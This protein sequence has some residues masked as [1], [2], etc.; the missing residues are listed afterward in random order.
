MCD[1]IK[2]NMFMMV[3]A[4]TKHQ[5]ELLEKAKAEAAAAGEEGEVAEGGEQAPVTG[6]NGKAPEAATKEDDE[7]DEVSEL[8]IP[9]PT[10]VPKV[11]TSL[12]L[13]SAIIRTTRA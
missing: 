4:Q 10:D 8:P 9:G 3:I 7:S 13:T 1:N 11:P 12:T 6:E 5:A 2:G